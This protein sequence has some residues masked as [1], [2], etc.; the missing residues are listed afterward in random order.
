MSK[1]LLLMPL[2]AVAMPAAAAES[3]TAYL[4]KAGAGDLYEQTSSKIVLETTRDA[5]VKSFATMMVGDH[6]KSTAMLKSAAAASGVKA[7]P[8]SLTPDQQ[9][10]VRALKQAKGAAR[11]TLYWQQQKAAHSQALQLHQD[12]AAHGSDRS[13]KD[14]AAKIVPVVKHHL[15]LLNAGR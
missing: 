8:P 14:A 11:D 6:G 15:D 13:L 12:Y 3:P 2:I 5:R 4:G 7:P 9:A 10:K 1:M